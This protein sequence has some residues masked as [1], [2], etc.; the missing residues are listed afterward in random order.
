MPKYAK[1]ENKNWSIFPK[2]ITIKQLLVLLSFNWIHTK[3]KVN[4]ITKLYLHKSKG[5]QRK[6]VT[7]QCRIGNSTLWKKFGE[8]GS[9]SSMSILFDTYYVVV[10]KISHAST[11]KD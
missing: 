1:P 11:F 6:C 4:R 7:F 2:H 8:K 10:E 5:F 9:L 3:I